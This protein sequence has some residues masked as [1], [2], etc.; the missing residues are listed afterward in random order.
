M[1]HG[2]LSTDPAGGET[3]NRR[4]DDPKSSW[5]EGR[6]KPVPYGKSPHRTPNP[7]SGTQ[8]DEADRQ[9]IEGDQPP[10]YTPPVVHDKPRKSR[11]EPRP[12]SEKRSVEHSGP[13]ERMPLMVVILLSLLGSLVVGVITLIIINRFFPDWPHRPT[14]Q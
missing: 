3:M 1:I 7:L 14:A 10:P 8:L 11:S 4:G 5:D 6:S 13:R 2:R 12:K 9:R